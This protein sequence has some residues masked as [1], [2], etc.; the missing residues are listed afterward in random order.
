MFRVFRVS[1][2]IVQWIS[3]DPYPRE[4]S[5][6]QEDAMFSRFYHKSGMGKHWVSELSYSIGKIP[7]KSIHH[8][9]FF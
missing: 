5:K 1:W 4:H 6:G 2:D 8:L 7:F 3:E 9:T